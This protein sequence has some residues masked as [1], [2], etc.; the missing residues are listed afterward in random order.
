[1]KKLTLIL[2]PL[3][4]VFLFFSACKKEKRV[5]LPDFPTSKT[6]I[7]SVK[8]NIG[9]HT[10]DMIAGVDEAFIE[11]SIERIN[12]I[13][14]FVGT[15]NKGSQS[16]TIKLSEGQIGQKNTLFNLLPKE[17]S[18]PT[19]LQS[20]IRLSKNMLAN[21]SNIKA[22]DFTINGKSIG[23]FLEVYHSGFYDICVHITFN[24]LS[25]HQLCNNVLLGYEDLGH[26]KMVQSEGPTNANSYLLSIQDPSSPIEHINW[27]INNEVVSSEPSLTLSGD[28]GIVL[29]DAQI[30]FNNGII[31][32]HSLLVDTDGQQ[33]NFP[34]LFSFKNPD[35][36][37]YYNDFKALLL[38]D[39]GQIWDSPVGNHQE[40]TGTLTIYSA[41]IFEKKPNG[42]TIYKV[43]GTIYGEC[44]D[45]TAHEIL[46]VELSL[47]FAIELP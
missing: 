16:F 9:N 47:V 19:S 32:K 45:P 11:T 37:G 27:M 14:F 10:I 22:I 20:W 46:P 44:F 23:D 38:F 36:S 4:C 18:F 30:T 24:D 35:V 17:F 43:E 3:F 25:E 12:Q 41:S 21:Q 5:E 7:F 13:P 8:G 33:R 42:N 28:Q 26:F 1:M 6:P 2:L 40:L 34:D 39:S 15:M 29:V 31:R